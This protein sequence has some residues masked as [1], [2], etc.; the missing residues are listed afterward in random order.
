MARNSRVP[1]AVTL[2]GAAAA[3]VAVAV[4]PHPPHLGPET[5]GDAALAQQLRD[6]AG[7]NGY[8]GLSVAL[9]EDGTVRT[10]G[11]GDTGGPDPQPVDGSTPF[12]IGSI[13]KGLTGMLLA[14]SGID[15][16]TP[17]SDLLPDVNFSDDGVG[18]A[19]LAELASHRSGLPRLRTTPLS[20][21]RGW[22]ANITGADPYASYDSDAVLAD[23]AAASAG[24][25]GEVS[26]SNLGMAL[27]GLALAEHA[28]TPY[29]DLLTARILEPLGMAGT[30]VAATES[31]L[32]EN[33]AHGSLVSGLPADPWLGQGWS[34]AGA[35]VWSTAD[36][37]AML[38][39]ALLDG[40]APGADAATPRFDAGDGERIGYGWFTETIDGREV[41]WHNGGTGGFRAWAG[42][43]AAAGMGV[44][45]L[46]N[47]DRPVDAI[48]LR[49]LGAD[50]SGAGG[51]SW[52]RVAITLGGALIG[53]LI[54]LANRRPDRLGLVRDVSTGI[55]V[56][57]V[58]RNIGT[59]DVIPPVVWVLGVGGLAA[60]AVARGRRWPEMPVRLYGR[61]WVR[62]AGAAFPA[63]ACAALVLAVTLLR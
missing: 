62:L 27:L 36:D 9:V 5:T 63:A 10:A 4:M 35:G 42:Y 37:L 56:L 46:G 39:R 2:A 8:R 22:V 30:V 53:G 49:L 43:D 15:P 50:P 25:K 24:G 52:W 23:A 54:V 29:R 32:P 12:E 1:T 57:L 38:L 6:A 58:V 18:S 14:D 48:G 13:T 7:E 60:A 26:Y 41:T 19:T 61:P 59:W 45:V 34:G 16:D 20:L 28:G 3:V 55:F 33:R 40:T 11:V 47:T 44:V 31:E 17:V 51:A 21:A